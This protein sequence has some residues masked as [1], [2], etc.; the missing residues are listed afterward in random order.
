[1]LIRPYAQDGL[2]SRRF[3]MIRPRMGTDR[4][5]IRRCRPVDLDAT[6]GAGLMLTGLNEWWHP[7]DQGTP[8]RLVSFRS[9]RACLT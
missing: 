4:E 9:S 3:V 6:T 7:G 8:P 2:S 1:M 5:A